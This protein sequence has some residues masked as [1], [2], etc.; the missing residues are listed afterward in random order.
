MRKT[1]FA[2]LFS[3]L[4]LIIRDNCVNFVRIWHVRATINRDSMNKTNQFEKIDNFSGKC[5]L[6]TQ[7]L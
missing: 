7:E 1:T 6:V 3:H 2:F 4:T 5:A